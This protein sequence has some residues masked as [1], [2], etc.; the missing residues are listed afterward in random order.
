MSGVMAKPVCWLVEDDLE[1]VPNNFIYDKV[2]ESQNLGI[3]AISEPNFSTVHPN[4]DPCSKSS[5]ISKLVSIE[6]CGGGLPMSSSVSLHTRAL[7]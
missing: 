2:E 4:P 3:D 1:T 5:S 7:Q 6:R